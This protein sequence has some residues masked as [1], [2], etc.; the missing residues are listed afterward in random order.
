MNKI[1]NVDHENDIYNFTETNDHH[2][3]PKQAVIIIRYKNT[4]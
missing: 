3:W 1:I 4:Q 2:K